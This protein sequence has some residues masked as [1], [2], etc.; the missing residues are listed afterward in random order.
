MNYYFFFW[1]L[2]FP[3]AVTLCLIGFEDVLRFTLLF[4]SAAV[5]LS[6][7]AL[8]LHEGYGRLDDPLALLRPHFFPV[9]RSTQSS[10]NHL[11]KPPLGLLVLS[12]TLLV[13]L[14]EPPWGIRRGP[15]LVF[16]FSLRFYS[17][18]QS[19]INGS[20]HLFSHLHKGIRP[21]HT[22]ASQDSCI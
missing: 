13:L 11:V 18:V 20:C 6:A 1:L 4:F 2:R 22:K 21:F 10:L 14:G 17:A 19:F 5:I 8:G 15:Y 9:L 16:L 12:A 3:D 7:T